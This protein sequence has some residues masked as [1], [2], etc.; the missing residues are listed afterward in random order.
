MKAGVAKPGGGSFR[1]ALLEAGTGAKPHHFF[2][3]KQG[4]IK[5]IGDKFSPLSQRTQGKLQGRFGW[6]T[7]YVSP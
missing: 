5:S 3:G 6:W 7:S 1:G 4:K 2:G